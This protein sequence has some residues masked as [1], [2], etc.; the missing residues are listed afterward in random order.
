MIL[1]TPLACLENNKEGYS[2]IINAETEER[3]PEYYN[4]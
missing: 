3:G 2:K 1:N 4:D